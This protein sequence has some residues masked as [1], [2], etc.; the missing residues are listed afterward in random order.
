MR[1]LTIVHLQSYFQPH[2]GYQEYFLCKSMA[3]AGHNVHIITSDR[4]ASFL[5][6]EKG[7]IV[8]CGETTM[9]GFYI[10]RLP[11]YFEIRGRVL[12]KKVF[13]KINELNPDILILHG[14]TNFSNIL[15]LLLRKRLKSKIIIDEHHIRLIENKSTLSRIFYGIWGIWYRKLI[16]KKEVFLVGVADACCKFLSEKYQIPLPMINLISLGADID[17]FKPDSEKRRQIRKRLKIQSNEVLIIYTGK[18]NFEKDPFILLKACQEVPMNNK[19]KFIFI[20]DKSNDYIKKYKEFIDFDNVIIF[21]AIQNRELPKYYAAADIACWPKHTSLS[22]LEAASCALPI[23]ISNNVKERVSHQ[24]GIAI[25]EENIID[26]KKAILKLSN[27]KKLRKTMGESGRSFINQKYSY[28]LISKQFI[29][30]A[31][32]QGGH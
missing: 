2:L 25:E 26:I 8:G 14:S 28:D 11:I 15:P 10:H 31:F 16:L 12:I 17:L 5:D 13:S 32:K 20:G 23:I 18:I 24:N 30:L 27:N 29:D 22:S 6:L 19:L 1:Q 3:K 7:R 4:Y 21:S 9:D